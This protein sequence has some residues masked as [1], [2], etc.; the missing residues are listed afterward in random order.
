VWH[1]NHTPA[2]PLPTAS[3]GPARGGVSPGRAG[4]PPGGGGGGGG[5]LTPPAAGMA[6]DVQGGYRAMCGRS[7]ASN[8][9]INAPFQGR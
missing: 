4:G 3:G 9:E 5:V 6:L 2:D 1:A 7:R 8:S